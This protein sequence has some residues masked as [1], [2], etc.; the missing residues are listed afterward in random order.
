LIA[1]TNFMEKLSQSLCWA[2]CGVLL[3]AL[4][5]CMPRQSET[6]DKRWKWN[7]A[8]LQGDYESHGHRDPKWDKDAGEAL[9]KFAEIRV[10]PEDDP[11]THAD[12]VGDSAESAVNAGCDDPLIKYLHC[13]YA[14][15]NSA[16]TLSQRQDEFRL[17]AKDLE[18]SGY[19]PARKFYANVDA[20]EWLWSRRNTNLWPEV[21]QFR[22]AA[23]GDLGQALQDKTLPGEEAYQACDAFFQMV[24][25][26][27]R[28]LTN[29]YVTIEK[30]L[31]NNRP[32]W[33]TAYLI[34]ADYYLLYAWRGRG[35][36]TADQ[37]TEE[38][39][40]LF[41]ERLAEA[42]QAL[43]RAW[44]LDPNNARTPVL[45][46]QVAEGQQKKRPEMESWFQRAM[47]LD[48]N[49]YEA[50]RGKLHYLYPQWYGSREDMLAFGRECV[51]STNWGGRVPLILVD[52]HSELA[53]SLSAA[54]RD[55]Y[56]GLP[57]VWPD[58]KAAY[59]K[60]SQANPDATRFRYPYAAY[61][62]RC[63]QWR[64]FNEQIALLRKTGDELNV[65]YF[66]GKEA[67]DKMA[68]IARQQK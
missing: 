13:R 31:F 58:I 45:M 65:S 29:A 51:V 54:D 38:G 46:I 2:G 22:A 59:E 32:R 11:E 30:L 68:E 47:N 43:K 60:Y 34:K 64:D 14:P 8:T 37:V 18:K 36:G 9:K 27:N 53:R 28:E 33:V 23:L 49:N 62:F 15:G 5:S 3:L 44:A 7:V 66:G 19:A 25:R 39:W 1:V 56:W 48:P 41:R 17:V 55:A 21:R 61:A 20:A 24:E 26:N 4:A 57:E 50:C 16:K 52:A 63:G 10:R 67:F 42:E 12:L 40:R 35:N 6:R